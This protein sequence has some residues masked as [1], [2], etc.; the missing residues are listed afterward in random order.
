MSPRANNAMHTDS[1][2]TFKFESAL[3][4]AAPVMANRSAK[5]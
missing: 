4:G 1:A 3:T 5:P 2:T